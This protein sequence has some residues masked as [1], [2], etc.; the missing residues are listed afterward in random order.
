LKGVLLESERELK[1]EI[2]NEVALL[3]KSLMVNIILAIAVV[4][5]AVLFLYQTFSS[6]ASKSAITPTTNLVTSSSNTN[7]PNI[8]YSYVA[9]HTNI[10]FN[11]TELSIIN[12]APLSYY[13]IAA[14]KLLN[15]TLTDRIVVQKGPQGNAIIIDGKPTVIYLGATSCIFCAENRWAMAL[16]LAKFGNFSA[17]YTG[18]SAMGD[19]HIPTIF[20]LPANIT[21]QNNVSYG[22]DYSSPYINFIAADYES[23]LSGGFE[24]QP[25]SYFLTKAPNATYS[26]AILFMNNSKLFQ[27]TPFTF[28]G[29]TFVTGADGIVF[30]NTT[31]TSASDIPLAYMTHVQVLNQ[32]KNFNDQFAWGEYAA[33]DVYIAYTC[34]S[35]NNNAP[36]C[37]LSGIQKLE[38]IIG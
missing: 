8:S 36:V 11:S 28:W 17:L 21:T 20:W 27:G 12:N 29:T 14:E 9:A 34:P 37:K 23:P 24:I 33:A 6:P 22:S 5:L 35:I 15:N 31:P 10:P 3:S 2:S 19:D 30:G 4:V 25:L 7:I 26:N 13:E 18:Y 1:K 32:L 38:S 16:A